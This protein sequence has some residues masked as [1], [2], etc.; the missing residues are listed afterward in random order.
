MESTI[1]QSDEEKQRA[2]EAARRLQ[3]EYTPLK[4]QLNQLRESIGLEKADDNEDEEVIVSFLSKLSTSSAEKTERRS[5]GHHHQANRSRASNNHNSSLSHKNSSD[6]GNTSNFHQ[7][8]HEFLQNNLNLLSNNLK[9]FNESKSSSSHHQGSKSSGAN[10][11]SAANSNVNKF[12]SSGQAHHFNPSEL[13]MG[14]QS[15]N[16][17]DLPVQLATAALMAHSLHSQSSAMNLHRQQAAQ[18]QGPASFN[19]FLSALESQHHQQQQQ[20]QQQQQHRE[21]TPSSSLQSIPPPFRQQPPPMKSCLSCH[22]QIHRNAPICPLCKAKSRSRNPKKPKK[23]TTPG[24][25]VVQ[26]TATSSPASKS[27]ALGKQQ[28]HGSR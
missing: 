7:A 9:S 15:S 27:S 16:P 5:H 12:S 8:S 6:S 22:Q 23:K 3:T 19:P 11:R 14:Q 17:L 2:L 26:P 20:Q 10:P 4:D 28:H 1:K 25:A 21:P 13:L 18:H 24:P